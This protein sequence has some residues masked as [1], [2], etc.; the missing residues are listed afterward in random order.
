MSDVRTAELGVGVDRPED[1]PV[2]EALL[3]S[4]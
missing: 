1:V 3:R 2:V 4:R